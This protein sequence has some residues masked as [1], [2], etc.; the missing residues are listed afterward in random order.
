MAINVVCVG[1]N[2]TRDP[3][4]RATQSGMAVLDFGVAVNERRKNSQ[5]GEWEDVPCFVDCTAFGNYA[6]AM[7]RHMAKGARVCVQGHLT[8]SQWK[9]K[10]GTRRSK[11][12]VI[13][14]QISVMGQGQAAPQQQGGAVEL[15]DSDIP[16]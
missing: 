15:A 16:F 9:A 1:G 5:T 8:F 12:S 10:D 3:E 7:S 2:L 14:D 13:A 6:E 11:L 4:L